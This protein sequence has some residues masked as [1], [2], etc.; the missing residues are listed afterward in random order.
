MSEPPVTFVA[1]FRWHRLTRRDQRL[2]RVLPEPSLYI[3]P[4]AS[5]VDVE[6]HLKIYERDRKLYVGGVDV[7]TTPEDFVTPYETVSPPQLAPRPM[8]TDL[9][10]LIPLGALEQEALEW[11]SSREAGSEVADILAERP[12]VFE[13][14]SKVGAPSTRPRRGRPPKLTPQLLA[15][16]AGAYLTGGRQGVR[17][18]QRALDEAGYEGNGPKGETTWDQAAKAVARAR[19]EGLLPPAGGRRKEQDV[20]LL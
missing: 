8:S 10:R 2:E 16:V 13:R 20:D 19:K 11:L 3:H 9:M 1:Y 6:V 4:W 12:D 7:R 17:A 18:V 5:G 15:I 14:F